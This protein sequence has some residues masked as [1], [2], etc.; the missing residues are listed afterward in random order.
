MRGMG[1]FQ[2]AQMKHRDARV[3]AMARHLRAAVDLWA[4]IQLY[5]F[6][7]EEPSGP[8][9]PPPAPPPVVTLPSEKLAYGIKEAAIALG[10]S[11][12]TIWRAMKEGKVSAVKVGNR[13]LIRTEALQAWLSVRVAG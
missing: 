2:R 11:K 9:S 1:D 10:V 4:E 13:T 5:P 8:P 3:S 6:K 7:K 12:T